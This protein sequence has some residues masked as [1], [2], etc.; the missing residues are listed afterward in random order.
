MKYLDKLLQSGK[1]VFTTQ[2]LG[3]IF[4][5]VNKNTIKNI[6]ARMKKNNI[7]QTLHYWIYWLPNYDRMELISKIKYPSYISLETVLQKEWVI[8][9]DYGN[10]FFLVSNNTIT[11][12][13]ADMSIQFHKIKDTILLSP[14]G[15]RNNGKYMIATPE[16][17]ICDR[18]YLSPNYYFDNT[19]WVN[20]ELLTQL[21]SIYPQTTALSI[22]HIID[23]NK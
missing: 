18:L 6:I 10:T 9:Q 12:Q 1:T 19:E 17:A 15:I 20:T 3:L 16:R 21:Q 4:R 23:D 11:H 13:I 2:E 8:F 7:L 14:I 22:Q 5:I